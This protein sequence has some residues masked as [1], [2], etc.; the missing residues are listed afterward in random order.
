MLFVIY[1]AQGSLYP[2]GSILS[3][4][5]LALILCISLFYFFR[6]LFTNIKKSTFYKAWTALLL[7]NIFGF[8]FTGTISDSFHVGMFKE[9]LFASLPFYPF[10]Y[11]A[12]SGV[13]TS[14]HLVRFFFLILPI[15][16]LQFYFN[17]NQILAE[18]ISDDTNV[19]NNLA[20]SFVAFIPFV[21]LIKKKILSFLVMLVLIFF[22]IQ[23]AKRGALIAG[24]IGLFVFLYYQLRTV[25]KKNKIK[26]YLFVA[27]GIIGMCYY[28]FNTF[29]NNEFMIERLQNM[30]EGSSSGRDMIY[31]N[32]FDGWV[33]S[34]S[35]LNLLFGFGF[36]ASLQLSGIGSLAHN[37]WLELLSNYGLLGV[38][39]YAILFYAAA[40]PIYSSKWLIDKK[41]V[42]ITVVVIW[43]F[44]TLIS[45][46]Y[47]SQSSY[48]YAI[49]LAYLLGSRS[50]NLT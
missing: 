1:Y 36:V 20:Y 43:F 16:I 48:I 41:L 9:I 12:Q 8:F 10:F 21:F 34:N 17:V 25:S 23:G 42:M 6:T 18:R 4:A 13:L 19:V 2:I 35:F 49:L 30:S 39:I 5:S 29:Q 14:K 38:C 3:Q 27:A 22:I 7:L 45:M 37:D 32:V 24:F 46:S 31:S 15:T 47:N 50:R 28:A 44:I 26:G 40:K 11:F 33:N